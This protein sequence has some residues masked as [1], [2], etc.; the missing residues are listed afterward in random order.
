M[1]ALC[2]DC[3]T[4]VGI[5]RFRDVGDRQRLRVIVFGGGPPDNRIDRK[6][7]SPSAALPPG[8]MTDSMNNRPSA[9]GQEAPP[10]GV[11]GFRPLVAFLIGTF[12]LIW[13]TALPLGPAV[14]VLVIVGQPTVVAFAVL[15]LYLGR[16]GV[17]G[18]WRGGTRWR[19]GTRWYVLVVIL[20]A[21]AAGAGWLAMSGFRF[22][23]PTGDPWMLA[24]VSGLL[25][26]VF[27]EFGWSG[28]AFPA[29]QARLGFLRAGVALGV[30]WA[31]WHLPALFAATPSL[32][33]NF[34][35]VPFLLLVIPVRIL[36][37]WIYNGTGGSILLAALFHASV[38]AWRAILLSPIVVANAG[39]LVQTLVFAAAVMILWLK[40]PAEFRT[41]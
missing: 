30:I 38:D 3:N 2:E 1:L 21:L 13:L 25:A 36:L 5:I 17:A 32:R 14:Y 24:V 10:A 11:V 31:L 4:V 20:P 16:K 12:A 7:N 40:R 18:L 19:V 28:V 26:G 27:E 41:S 37:G 29:L 6:N 9:G 34:S 8:E 35:F 22:G 33:A 39:W 23:T 15:A